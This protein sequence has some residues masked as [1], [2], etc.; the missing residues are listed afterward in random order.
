VAVAEGT[1][2][3]EEAAPVAAP[4]L[5][6]PMH[7]GT[8]LLVGEQ[9]I[10]I[11]ADEAGKIDAYYLATPPDAPQEAQVTAYVPD[12]EGQARPVVLTWDPD[13]ARYTGFLRG[14]HLVP[15]P[16]EIVYVLRGVTSRATAPTFVLVQPAVEAVEAAA[17][18]SAA[19]ARAVTARTPSAPAVEVNVQPPSSPT[20]VVNTPAPPPPPVVVAPPAPPRPHVVV[21]PPAPPPPPR[22]VVQPAAPPPPP[23]VVVQPPAPPQP[24]VVVQPPAPPPPPRVVVQPAAPPPPPRVVVERPARPSVVVQPAGGRPRV[25]ASRGREDHPGRGRGRGHRDRDD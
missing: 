13:G 10:E 6:E 24:R 21:Q 17:G 15:G 7:G 4:A 2:A 8:V 18:A 20:V 3:A 23:R 19:A 5:P 25:E 11:V 12:S 16:L 22:V 1:A 14:A 9:P